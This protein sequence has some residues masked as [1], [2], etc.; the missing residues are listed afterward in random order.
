MSFEDRDELIGR[1]VKMK[2]ILMSRKRWAEQDS[3]DMTRDE[4]TTERV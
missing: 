1:A 2:V 4:P 3:E